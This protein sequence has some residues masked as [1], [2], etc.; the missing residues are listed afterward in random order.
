MSFVHCHKCHWEQDD[1][2][3]PKG[4]NPA[5]YLENWM[6]DLCLNPDEPFTGDSQW[7]R[8]HGAITYR[9]LIAREFECYARKIRTMKWITYED[10][11]NE[12]NKVCPSCGSNDL[13]ID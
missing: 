7:I 9:E 5:H 2:Y 12:P 8:E 6:K 13:D 3:S 4:Y 1:F 11:K 10:F